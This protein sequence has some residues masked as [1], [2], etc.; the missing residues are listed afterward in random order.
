M[1]RRLARTERRENRTAELVP[2]RRE[3]GD[4]AAKALAP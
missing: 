3:R 2:G 1:A 4:Q